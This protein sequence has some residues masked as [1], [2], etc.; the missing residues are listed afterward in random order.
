MTDPLNNRILISIPNLKYFEQL[1]YRESKRKVFFDNDNDNR[2]GLSVLR[3]RK[4]KKKV[5]TFERVC[6]LYL[7]ETSSNFLSQDEGERFFLIII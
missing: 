5:N 1:L 7:V 4:I 3:K 2:I 6:R